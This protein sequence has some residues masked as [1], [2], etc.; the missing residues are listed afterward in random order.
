MQKPLRKLIDEIFD[1]MDKSKNNKIIYTIDWLNL[2]T[3]QFNVFYSFLVEKLE[4]FGYKD[5]EIQVR[6]RTGK[7]RLIIKWKEKP[8]NAV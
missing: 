5:L 2:P 1:K 4:I 3:N 8:K 6:N 7:Y